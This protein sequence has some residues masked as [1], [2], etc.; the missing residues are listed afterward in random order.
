VQDRHRLAA[1]DVFRVSAKEL[2]E[3]GPPVH[4]ASVGLM[5]PPAASS[6]RSF[7]RASN[8]SL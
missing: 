8:M 1:S 4:C 3:G 7:C 5:K 2:I 6:F